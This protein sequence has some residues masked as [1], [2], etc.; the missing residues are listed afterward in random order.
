MTT[1]RPWVAALALLAVFW[2]SPVLA[3]SKSS[4]EEEAPVFRFIDLGPLSAAILNRN[5]VRG[6][7]TIQITIEILK[8]EAATEVQSKIPRVQAA[9][10]NVYQRHIGRLSSPSERL[11]LEVMIGDMRRASDIVIGKDAIRPLIQNIQYS[12]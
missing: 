6:L 1:S 10:L 8:P 12:R 3:A 2:T 9:W 4:A 7:V 5:R 11:D